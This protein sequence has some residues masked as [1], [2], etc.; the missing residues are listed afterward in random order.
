MSNTSTKSPLAMTV[1]ELAQIIRRVDG[2]N[3]LGA[4][5]LA[6]AIRA[7]LDSPPDHSEGEGWQSIET[8]P[9]DGTPILVGRGRVNLGDGTYKD[10]IVLEAQWDANELGWYFGGYVG[11]WLK[12]DPEHPPTHWQPLP[13]PPHAS[14][15][16]RHDE[17]AK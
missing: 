6:E 3:K 12:V 9:K 1:D 15:P 17:Q 10:G 13:E 14:L 7:A 8:A 2:E 5:A 4:G 16:T 11:G